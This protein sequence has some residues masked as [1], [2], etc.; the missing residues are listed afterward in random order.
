MDV[1]PSREIPKRDLILH[2]R[3]S[4][5]C[6][7]QATGSP[8][9]ITAGLWDYDEPSCAL[10]PWTCEPTCHFALQSSDWGC[11]GLPPDVWIVDMRLGG[12]FTDASND[13]LEG[14]VQIS[15]DH[16][17]GDS[18]SRYST[19]SR[20]A[21]RWLAPACR[22]ALGRAYFLTWRSNIWR[23]TTRGLTGVAAGMGQSAHDSKHDARRGRQATAGTPFRRRYSCAVGRGT[24]ARW[25]APFPHQPRHSAAC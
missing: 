16:R 6:H 22:A 24:G 20:V 3:A 4:E 17:P 5:K 1:T 21:S 2:Q 15:H 19:R 12:R 8:P 9:S 23:R 14:S 7:L 11:A 25:S 10:V 18:R 13:R